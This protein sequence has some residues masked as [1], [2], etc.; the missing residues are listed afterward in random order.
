MLLRCAAHPKWGVIQGCPPWF[1]A[2]CMTGRNVT[3]EAMTCFTPAVKQT[4]QKKRLPIDAL[5]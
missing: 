1:I 2:S 3:Q 4:R 5:L